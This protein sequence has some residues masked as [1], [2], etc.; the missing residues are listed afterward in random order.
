[1]EIVLLKDVKRL[2][3]EGAVLTVRP[4][5]ARNF[6]IPNGLAVLAPVQQ[7][8]AIEERRVRRDQRA[9]KV[10]EQADALKRK[11]EGRSLTLTLSLGEENKSF[12]SITTHDVVEALAKES[13]P[14][15]KH[16]VRLEEP[17][18]TLGFYEVPVRL[19]PDVTA[20]LKLVVAKA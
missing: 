11:I 8:K 9:A 19:H 3:E 7:L 14:V 4:G 10:R 5:Y 18:K 16:A 15:D 20:I 2:G 1:M 6:L 13:L 17:I 12:G